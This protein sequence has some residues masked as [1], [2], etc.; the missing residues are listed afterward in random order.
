MESKHI[1]ISA[2]DGVN[3]WVVN[4]EPGEVSI[5]PKHSIKILSNEESDKITDKLLEEEATAEINKSSQKKNS[6]RVNIK[7][8]TAQ[9]M[10][11]RNISPEERAIALAA[12]ARP[13]RAKRVD[14]KAMVS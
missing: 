4:V 1:L 9:P 8:A 7:V 11:D 2:R 13:K 6:D 12:P 10:E 3:S 14:Y 5:W